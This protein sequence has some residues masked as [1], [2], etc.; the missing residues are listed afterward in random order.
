MTRPQRLDATWHRPSAH[1]AEGARLGVNSMPAV[2]TAPHD[3]PR[4]VL[5]NGPRALR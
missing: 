4:R 5:C 2:T 3:R 1:R